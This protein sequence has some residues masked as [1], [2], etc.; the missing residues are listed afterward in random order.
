MVRSRN[1]SVSAQPVDWET[2]DRR[3]ESID[4]KARALAVDVCAERLR[5]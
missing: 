5:M 4:L 3:V 1:R 2:C